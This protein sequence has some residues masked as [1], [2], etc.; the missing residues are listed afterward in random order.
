[1]CNFLHYAKM[2]GNILLVAISSDASARHLKGPGRPIN[3]EQDRLALVAA[4]DMV[5][6]SLLFEADTA[7]DLIRILHPHLYVKGSDYSDETLPEAEVVHE[8][9]GHIVILPLAGSASTSRMIERIK[10]Y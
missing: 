9:G 4:L 2:L 1:M 10:S 7:R 5:D 6:Y 3:S 8:G